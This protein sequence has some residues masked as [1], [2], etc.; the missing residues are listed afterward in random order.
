M[1]LQVSFSRALV[2]EVSFVAKCR[3]F[4]AA[5]SVLILA[6]P[7]HVS[8]EPPLMQLC[9]ASKESCMYKKKPQDGKEGLKSCVFILYAKKK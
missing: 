1:V 6:A 2:E 4:T 3:T 9:K 8:P 7:S 5:K